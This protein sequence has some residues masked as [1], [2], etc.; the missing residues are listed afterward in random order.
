ML[1]RGAHRMFG[2]FAGVG[3]RPCQLLV[4][5]KSRLLCHPRSEDDRIIGWKRPLRSS[6]PTIYPT[7][8]CLRSHIPKCHIYTSFEHLQAWGLHHLPGQPV[9]MPDHSFSKEIFPN[10]QSKS[11]LMQLEATASRP[12]ASYLGEETNTCLTTTS[13]QVLVES[14]KVP[15]SA[16]SSPD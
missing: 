2:S 15:P 16:S 1:S 7:S 5:G 6:G 4:A 12:I 10:I 3:C 9:P 11:P 13:F 14:N 8:P